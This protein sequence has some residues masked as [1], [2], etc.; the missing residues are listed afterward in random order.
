MLDKYVSSHPIVYK[1]LNNI[2]IN[3]K[4]S[5]AY[6]FDTNFCEDAY[7]FILDFVKFIICH[8]IID[9]KKVESICKRIDSGNY[10][11]V[12]LIEA[13]GLWIKKE[14]MLN[15]QDEFNK[16]SFEGT[17]KIYIIKSAEKMNTATAN[18]IL[19]FLEE[20]VDD[21]V[22]IL[23][24]DNV[25]LIL[26]TILSR[27]QIIKLD[28]NSNFLNSVFLK[29]NIS[30]DDEKEYVEK[31]ISFALFLEDNG[32]DTIIYLKNK[33][34]N[35]FKDRNDNIL[36]VEIL[37][38]LYYDI[39]R[40]K[41]S[42]NVVYFDDYLDVIEKISNDNSIDNLIKKIEILDNVIS[43]LKS[44]LNINLLIDRMIIEMCG[45]V[46]GTYRS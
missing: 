2:V 3:D 29:K 10:L 13:D 43:D 41:N 27:C 35:L 17:R 16:K 18:S 22:A 36:A 39:V 8:N 19:K 34:H 44:N 1:I 7:D 20:P 38:N 42:M 33:W 11:D 26:P 28:G 31:V 40:F 30:L 9:E 24:T 25:N 5:H 15:L 46:D 4:I 45:D 14:Q 6:L 23:V 37:I 21:I 32:M 12:K